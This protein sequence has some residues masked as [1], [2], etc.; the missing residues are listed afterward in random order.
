MW[1]V[2]DFLL[3]PPPPKFLCFP[4]LS[5]IHSNCK[6]AVWRDDGFG[7]IPCPHAT[8]SSIKLISKLGKLGSLL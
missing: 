3:P 1:E 7:Y 4:F 2:H 5:H 6:F 8:S